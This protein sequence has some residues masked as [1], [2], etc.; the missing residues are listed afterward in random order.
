RRAAV[1]CVSSLCPPAFVLL[2]LPSLPTRRSSDLLVLVA[3]VVGIRFLQLPA[4]QLT[5][6]RRVALDDQRVRGHVVDPA[7]QGRTHGGLDRSEEHT[8]E[9]QSRFELVCRLLLEKRKR[10]R[11]RQR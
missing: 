8:S 3:H 4:A 5:G 10:S 7:V 9:L 11:Y 6:H 2:H 1:L